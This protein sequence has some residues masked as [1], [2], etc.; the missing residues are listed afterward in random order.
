[1]A[2]LDT[3]PAALTLPQELGITVFSD[4][5]TTRCVLPVYDRSNIA[6][7][8]LTKAKNMDEFLSARIQLS[9][10]DALRMKVATS[11]KTVENLLEELNS[12][13]VT[14][15]EQRYNISMRDA[16][17]NIIYE[18]SR[19]HLD[20]A[21]R[22]KKE[23]HEAEEEERRLAEEE[24]ARQRRIRSGDTARRLVN[25]ATSDGEGGEGKDDED[26]DGGSGVDENGGDAA[27]TAAEEEA[28]IERK[29][30]R[31]LFNNRRRQQQLRNQRHDAGDDDNGGAPGTSTSFQSNLQTIL[32]TVEAHTDIYHQIMEE[33]EDDL[34]D[35]EQRAAS[36]LAVGDG[37]DGDGNST[38]MYSIRRP[39]AL[40]NDPFALASERAARAGFLTAPGGGGV[41]HG[42]TANDRSNRSLA[43][44]FVSGDA[45][46]PAGGL[47]R[48]TGTL[49][50]P[51]AAQQHGGVSS[52][53]NDRSRSFTAGGTCVLPGSITKAF[54]DVPVVGV[55]SSS[56]ARRGSV[57]P[58]PPPPKDPL[59]NSA[60][61]AAAQDEGR[62]RIDDDSADD[63]D[64]DPLFQPLRTDKDIRREEEATCLD[65]V[66]LDT[67]RALRDVEQQRTFPI[68]LHLQEHPELRPPPSVLAASSRPREEI[69]VSKKDVNS[70]DESLQK[71]GG[72]G[73]DS[74]GSVVDTAAMLA[75]LDHSANQQPYEDAPSRQQQQQKKQKRALD[76]NNLAKY[77]EAAKAAAA[78]GTAGGLS[79]ALS[80]S[81][82]V[83]AMGNSVG[84]P[85][86]PRFAM[87]QNYG[88][89]GSLIDQGSIDGSHDALFGFYGIDPFEIPGILKSS[90]GHGSGDA[91]AGI[92]AAFLGGGGG[93]TPRPGQHQRP[94]SPV[95]P[96]RQGTSP[97]SA[98]LSPPKLLKTF[99]KT[100]RYWVTNL[101]T[102]DVLALYITM[103]PKKT[104]DY[105]ATAVDAL[106]A[107]N[108]PNAYVA[109]VY[110]MT[111][112]QIA[113]F[114]YSNSAPPPADD[115]V[116]DSSTAGDVNLG[117]AGPVLEPKYSLTCFFFFEY[118][119]SAPPPAD[120]DVVDSST[121]DVKL[122]DAGP[123]LEPKY[124]LTCM[125]LKREKRNENDR[126]PTDGADSDSHSQ[127]RSTVSAESSFAHMPSD[128]FSSRRASRQS[129]ANLRT[130]SRE[131]TEQA[132]QHQA[133]AD[134]EK[135][136]RAEKLRQAMI[137]NQKKNT[138]STSPVPKG[139]TSEGAYENASLKSRTKST[140][141]R[142]RRL[143]NAS[144]ASVT[145]LSGS[146]GGPRRSSIGE[147]HGLF[148][149][150]TLPPSRRP[151]VAQ[152]VGV[153]VS[154]T[155]SPHTEGLD[156]WKT[157]SGGVSSLSDP[158]FVPKRKGK[159][160]KVDDLQPPKKPPPAV[161]VTLDDHISNPVDDPS[162]QESHDTHAKPPL[163]STT[164]KPMA[165]A[166]GPIGKIRKRGGSH[167]NR[168]GRSTSVTL[169][170]ETSPLFTAEGIEATVTTEDELLV[171]REGEGN[172]IDD[173]DDEGT[174]VVGQQPPKSSLVRRVQ[175]DEQ[176]DEAA[177]YEALFSDDADDSIR[178]R[179]TSSGS[180]R[181]GLGVSVD[182]AGSPLDGD[183]ALDGSQKGSPDAQSGRRHTESFHTVEALLAQRRATNTSASGGVSIT[184]EDISPAKRALLARKSIA[185]AAS[186][187]SKA[188][189][190]LSSAENDASS[191]E[192]AV[193]GASS[194]VFAAL[195]AGDATS[196]SIDERGGPD[197]HRGGATIRPPTASSGVDEELANVLSSVA[198][199]RAVQVLKD[200]K[201]PTSHKKTGGKKK[202]RGN[203]T[204]SQSP[205]S[206]SRTS[207]Q[208]SVSSRMTPPPT[209]IAVSKIFA[210]AERADRK[211]A[212]LEGVLRSAAEQDALDRATK[213]H[214]SVS[215]RSTV[216]T[217]PL[218]GASPL[219]LS[220]LGG[221]KPSNTSSVDVDIKASFAMDT[222]STTTSAAQP[223]LSA[224][225]S[226]DLPSPASALM[227]SF[228]RRS[229]GT[230]MPPPPPVASGVPKFSSTSF[231]S[232]SVLDGKTPRGPRSSTASPQFD[233][234][235]LSPTS[236]QLGT[237][238][239]FTE[240]I[241]ERLE[242]L[243][244]K[245]AGEG[246]SPRRGNDASSS[247]VTSPISPRNASALPTVDDL[248]AGTELQSIKSPV[249]S[250]M[251]SA[252]LLEQQQPQPQR[253]TANTGASVVTSPV[254]TTIPTAVGGS[255][256]NSGNVSPMATHT[257][258]HLPF[259]GVEGN[260][261]EAVENNESSTTPPSQKEPLLPQSSDKKLQPPSSIATSDR[262]LR[263]L[264][265]EDPDAFS[266][267]ITD[268][269]ENAAA[270]IMQEVLATEG[271]IGEEGERQQQPPRAS[272]PASHDAALMDTPPPLS[273]QLNTYAQYVPPP[274]EDPE[275]LRRERAK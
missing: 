15:R 47:A 81:S 48:G 268:L 170:T 43:T 114:E 28:S 54:T 61:S 205:T 75:R 69:D 30:S 171:P 104:V 156:G 136:E 2:E 84:G 242:D 199:P 241:R 45:S 137:L 121:R 252:T 20:A 188:S 197:G 139:E 115:D 215:P 88:V 38:L 207:P 108:R 185:A 192:S 18:V 97:N 55:S 261:S 46:S 194:G 166:S 29:K 129:Q 83:G 68:Y 91:V 189:P 222:A 190:T 19:K 161:G 169:V 182:S 214:T 235:T 94:I 33:E 270:R 9:S 174:P 245:V 165:P 62:A 250:R 158:A 208:H 264:F 110:P 247:L 175:E 78:D 25:N 179:R 274:T 216:L 209:T 256:V 14:S 134:K 1:M 35:E 272:N 232:S 16:V 82:G 31:I 49:A 93:T 92:A 123:V 217:P 120:D 152:G 5:N 135:Q 98:S 100:V 3:D 273:D 80:F 64:N 44:A 150:S 187:Q 251:G 56:S 180:V 186:S 140:A 42:G 113:V 238:K 162:S 106:R 226:D 85:R 132:K 95:S 142:S 159:T 151:S 71:G 198:Q 73:G 164:T 99:F 17:N 90:G 275:V 260:N 127:Q 202:Q 125:V 203:S 109:R 72:A 269:A 12:K 26:R 146:G 201:P 39:S 248:L 163:A 239:T 230:G 177:L 227:S 271:R 116:V 6:Q 143:S 155:T 133:I 244:A 200:E 70:S 221:E 32:D 67:V 218:G 4:G 138:A 195:G 253:H 101:S 60:L 112:L 34:L 212:I 141:K 160:P 220:P 249:R 89:K 103:D 52:F 173:E 263:L 246:L 77:G 111:M 76:L 13:K 65:R 147:V 154:S 41:G 267:V 36:F 196:F 255:V 79:G 204:A 58:P 236:P 211:N 210:V 10:S 86:S 130:T 219:H 22:A 40:E 8:W 168:R 117:G 262:E 259:D 258:E 27:A 257:N 66:A 124:S 224:P 233:A 51:L 107:P 7:Y 11:V 183:P 181:S 228:S 37:F 234:S 59:Y 131:T 206:S 122:G 57:A 213:V 225:H 231:A 223:A 87:E 149:A 23:A 167:K 53:L 118:S 266:D 63:D 105:T 243:A 254:I 24:E 144:T 50:V 240:V 237:T 178:D 172:D 157:Q 126:G 74:D 96:N 153:A 128:A 145:T 176:L 148:D 191:F 193:T 119:N 229:S 265:E 184:A 102:T 21:E